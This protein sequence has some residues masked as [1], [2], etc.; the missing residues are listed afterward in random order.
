[1]KGGRLFGWNIYEYTSDTFTLE[2]WNTTTRHYDTL[3]LNP[4]PSPTATVV[5]SQKNATSTNTHFTNYST[6]QPKWATICLGS[7]SRSTSTV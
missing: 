1:M 3:S 7:S 4:A 2:Y 5:L 6:H